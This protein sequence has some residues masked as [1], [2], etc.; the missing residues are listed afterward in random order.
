VQLCTVFVASLGHTSS[1]EIERAVVTA[2]VNPELD[3]ALAELRE[4][5]LSVRLH[6]GKNNTWYIS[7][8]GLYRGYIAS[9][10]ELVDLRRANELNIRG[11]KD[12]G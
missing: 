5:G 6:S 3:T 2:S 8:G 12:L 7:D 4:Q 10:N 1:V 9:G 11:I